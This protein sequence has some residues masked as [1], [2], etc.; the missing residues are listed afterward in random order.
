MPLPPAGVVKRH[1]RDGV[2]P[3]SVAVL[4]DGAPRLKVPDLYYLQ[5]ENNTVIS[6]KC[7]V[8]NSKNLL[9][10]VQY[11]II[12]VYFFLLWISCEVT[13]AR[14]YNESIYYGKNFYF[15]LFFIYSFI[16]VLLSFA[17][18]LLQ[19]NLIA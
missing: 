11:N 14:S 9:L 16:C 18:C 2:L 3:V 10:K 12:S 7:V 19:P 1:T 5:T 4:K 15:D 13:R 6:I 8:S 17:K